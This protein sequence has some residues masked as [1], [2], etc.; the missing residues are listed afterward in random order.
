MLLRILAFQH[1]SLLTLTFG[2]ILPHL[3]VLQAWAPGPYS[4]SASQPDL[5]LLEA[6][7]SHLL[8]PCL[9]LGCCVSALFSWPRVVASSPTATNHSCALPL[10]A[11]SHCH[12]LALLSRLGASASSL[13]CGM[14]TAFGG[15]KLG[16]FG[17]GLGGKACVTHELWG[18]LRRLRGWDRVL[19]RW[20]LTWVPW[21]YLVE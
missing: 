10:A 14:V 12:G 11:A 18:S 2:L 3:L 9:I 4:P 8:W 20:T 17:S 21:R 13:A 5:Q 19:G 7:S 6:C 1:F 16:S 15:H